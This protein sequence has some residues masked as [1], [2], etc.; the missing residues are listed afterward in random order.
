MLTEPKIAYRETIRKK[1]DQE[2][3]YKK[4]SGGHGQYG[5]VKI[6]FEPGSKEGLDFTE[7]IFGGSVPK[8]FHPAVEKGLQEAMQKGVLAGFPVVNLKANLYDGSYHPVDSSELAF[9]MAASIAYKEGLKKAQP[10]ILE[11]VGKLTVWVPDSQVGDIIGGIS[12]RRGRVL[13]MTPTDKKGEQMVEA[14]VPFAEMADYA[15]ALRATAQ[16]RASYTF[17]FER[18]E[19]TPAEISAKIIADN[20]TGE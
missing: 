9:K 11:P 6:T 3:K 4:Q 12:K 15:V 2:G 20:Q 13:G 10:V 17:Y 16:G 8:N 18:Y 14:E 19:E 7:T 1:V 5:H